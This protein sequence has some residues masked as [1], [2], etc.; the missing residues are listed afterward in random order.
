MN[1]RQSLSRVAW[2][3]TMFAVM[4]VSLYLILLATLPDRPSGP[5]PIPGATVEEQAGSVVRRGFAMG[6][7]Y[8]ST[9]LASHSDSWLAASRRF[10]DGE[11]WEAVHA[12]WANEDRIWRDE[13]FERIIEPEID[14]L[15]GHDAADPS[16]RR[17]ATLFVRSFAAGLKDTGR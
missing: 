13:P 2:P 16:R 11:T 8:R 1:Y 7:Q 17:A 14:K 5:P 10:E 4:G 3:A 9:L 12:R 15:I 6:K